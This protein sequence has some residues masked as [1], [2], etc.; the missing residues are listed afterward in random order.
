[1]LQDYPHA[2][3]GFNIF[4]GSR[5]VHNNITFAYYE[6][7]QFNFSPRKKDKISV[8]DSLEISYEHGKV[9]VE[10]VD[11][12]WEHVMKETKGIWWKYP[13]FKDMGDAVEIVP[14][15]FQMILTGYKIDIPVITPV[16]V[17]EKEI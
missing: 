13:A 4:S 7:E 11:E 14:I 15:N 2:C 9:L 16:D 8:G 17:M 10:K 6:P 3:S 1:M 12:N 5:F